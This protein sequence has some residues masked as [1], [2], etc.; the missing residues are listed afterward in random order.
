MEHPL[1]NPIRL[2]GQ[3]GIKNKSKKKKKKNEKREEKNEKGEKK[4]EKK[5]T[6]QNKKCVDNTRNANL[7]RRV[8]GSPKRYGISG[9]WFRGGLARS[10][11]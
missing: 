4:E 11:G 1:I 8:V 6:K 7:L 2:S 9:K 5:K 10:S 3:I